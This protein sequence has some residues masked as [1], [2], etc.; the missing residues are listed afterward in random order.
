MNKKIKEHTQTIGEIR[1]AGIRAEA[2]KDYKKYLK[3][4]IQSKYKESDDLPGDLKDIRDLGR[5]DSLR[6][7][8]KLLE[9]K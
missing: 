8:L 2:V 7:V 3:E 4:Q 1:L 9:M 6:W 5:M